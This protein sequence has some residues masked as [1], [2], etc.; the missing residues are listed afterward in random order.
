MTL[1]DFLES[2]YHVVHLCVGWYAHTADIAAHG[3]TDVSDLLAAR[4]HVCGS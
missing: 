2:L 4:V 3:R 1:N